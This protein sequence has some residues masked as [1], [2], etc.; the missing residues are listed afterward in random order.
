MLEC[1][2]DMSAPSLH[3]LGWHAPAIE[4]VADKLLELNETNPVDFRRA[5]VVV[6]T[7]ESGR[8][9]REYMAE[10]AGK[11]IL[12]PRL[13][14]AGQLIPCEGN[15]V[16]TDEETLAAWLE[17]AEKDAFRNLL[18]HRDI[19]ENERWLLDTVLHL[20]HLRLRLEK[21][22]CSPE[23]ITGHLRQRSGKTANKSAQRVLTEEQSKWQE[24]G[25]LFA[26]VDNTLRRHNLCPQEEARALALAPDNNRTNGS[27]LIVA[28]VPELSRQLQIY[29][30]SRNVRVQIW[31]NAPATEC[32]NFDTWG[33]PLP[34]AWSTRKI[35]IPN[36]L[37]YEEDGKVN[38]NASTLHLTDDG[39]AAAAECVRLVH[40]VVENPHNPAPNLAQEVLIS[41][42]DTAFTPRLHAAFRLAGGEDWVL[43]LPEGRSLL[44]MD[45]AH[46]YGRLAAA[47]RTFGKHPIYDEASGKILHNNLS[48][49][50]AFC[51]LLRNRAFQ[52]MLPAPD[53]REEVVQGFVPHL[54][55]L[56]QSFLP[57]S[58]SRLLYLLNPQNSL[59][60]SRRE[61]TTQHKLLNERKSAY[62]RYALQ[63][64]TLVQ[65]CCGSMLSLHTLNGLAAQMQRLQNESDMPDAIRKITQPLQMLAE[66]PNR[67]LNLLGRPLLALEY[68]QLRVDNLAAGAL[69]ETR[70]EDTEL[71]VPGWKE[72]TFCRGQ[73]LIINAMHDGCIPEPL[74]KEELL[75]ESLCEELGLQHT[76]HREARDAFLLT[77]L[78]HSRA[79]G[80]VHFVMAR[81]SADGAPLS[82][83][84]LLLRCGQEA[85]GLMTLARRAHYLFADNTRVKL[86]PE[87]EICPLRATVPSHGKA[88]IAPG[89]MESVSDILRE[90][91]SNPFAPGTG[92]I[93]ERR[94][95]PSTL[96]VFLECPL[97]FWI[98]NALKIDPSANHVD[99]KM[100]PESAEYGTGMHAVLDRLVAEFPSLSVL[101]ERCP[102][103]LN[104]GQYE[105]SVTRRAWELADSLLATAYADE[106]VFTLPMQA[107]H[108]MMKRTLAQF[109][110]LHVDELFD[111]W[112]NAA[113]ELKVT[114]QMGLDD[115]NSG[116]LVGFDMTIDRV[117]YNSRTNE[118]RVLDYKTS[119]EPKEPR[120]IHYEEV[121]GGEDS[122][123][124][125]FMNSAEQADFPLCTARS[126]KTQ[127]Q[128]RWRNVQLPLYTYA[129]QQLTT[130]D[131]HALLREQHFTLCPEV[132]EHL[133]NTPGEAPLLDNTLP[134]MGYCSL[135][136]KTQLVAYHSLM[137]R[138]KAKE[139]R[140]YFFF[141]ENTMEHYESA[142]KTVR[143]AVKLIR[144][145]LCLYSAASLELKKKPFA[146][147]GGLAPSADPREIFA[148]PEL[149]K[150][151]QP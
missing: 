148:L 104:R 34:A 117:D 123:F 135:A 1:R 112:C 96:A 64:A 32:Q 80:D 108:S 107:R 82:A 37:V 137:N 56:L 68:L 40:E 8:R 151:P 125:R 92:Q 129:L 106:G 86:P 84:P 2:A 18:P 12:M 33:Q 131:F 79:P 3:F 94:Y 90:G 36:A 105:E 14:L 31:V 54:E 63:A 132:Q 141:P 118:W 13:T 42:C 72:L 126:K 67:G 120:K 116:E 15:N 58:V 88:K 103:A 20:Q 93:A 7:A 59:P 149:N 74:A 91:E 6:P 134:E 100:E 73:R 49:P 99:N 85:E 24:M 46:M 76:R 38:N 47:C 5:T 78:L 83:S 57:G 65:N 144:N 145:G 127:R 19:F 121:P 95:S 26:A 102:Q 81:Q 28:C 101:Q 115:D 75:P 22:N 55:A 25:E 97:T 43:N 48:Q 109:V 27:L 89:H 53:D 60:I 66:A 139:P 124:Y 10:R 17:V 147:Y 41:C 113:R 143:S 45:A 52:R 110:H 69:P 29:L 35:D 4:L 146:Q 39:D 70:R 44:T 62:Y 150:T 130:A 142:I 16:A 98:K 128:Y 71:D 77:A 61:N 122:L 87:P 114:P 133:S 50:D 140:T 11:P 30:Q 23:R 51:A 138:D 136:T 21:E 9:L 119:M 111:G